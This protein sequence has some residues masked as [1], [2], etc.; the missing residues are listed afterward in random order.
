MQ[1]HL[2]HTKTRYVALSGVLADKGSVQKT[3][4]Q[5]SWFMLASAVILQCS[6]KLFLLADIVVK[7]KVPYFRRHG[8]HLLF[9]GCWAHW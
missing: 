4:G 5:F 2:T 9:Y 7:A 6:A 3:V 8:A 1:E